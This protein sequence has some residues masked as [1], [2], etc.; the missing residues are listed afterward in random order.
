MNAEA[1]L[2]DSSAV[3]QKKLQ[4]NRLGLWLFLISDAFMFGG[5]MVTRGVL[6]VDTRPDLN[7][8]LGLIVTVVLLVSSFFMNRAETAMAH[9]DKKE[10]IRGTAITLALGIIFLVG[11]VG[12]E[13]PL[14]SSHGITP[15]KDVYG[16]V[17]FM[18]TGMHAFHVLTGIIF[19]VIIL[20]NGMRDL[21]SAEKH[22]AV[23]A[24]AVYWH[25]I[26]VV[27]IFF[28]PAIYLI[29]QVV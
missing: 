11:V 3:Y 17:F 27:W 4:I 19:L 21:Y 12:L 26:D 25:F 20:R 16:A 7:Q 23:E 14:A 6:W 24:A 10:F 15:G 8:I 9:G 29:G 13:W 5:L 18:M 22:L 2:Q 1:H 28:Y